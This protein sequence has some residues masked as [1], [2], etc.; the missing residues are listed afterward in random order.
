MPDLIGRTLG[1]YRITAKIGEGGMG[2]VYRAQDERL[3]RD[4]AI[5]LLPEEVARTWDRLDRFERGAKAVARLDH[6][7]ILAIHD[8]GSDED[9]TYSITELLQGETL[10]GASIFE[11]NR[12]AVFR[13]PVGGAKLLQRADEEPRGSARA[14]AEKVSEISMAELAPDFSQPRQRRQPIGRLSVVS[15]LKE[16]LVFGGGGRGFESTGGGILQD[17]GAVVF[18]KRRSALHREMHDGP[19]V[20]ALGNDVAL[21]RRGV[22][23]DG[24]CHPIHAF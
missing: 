5:K 9:V 4:V 19:P 1:H 3:D 17:Q 2:E 22:Q 11:P 20:E 12:G 16:P 21:G 10:R 13:R 7:N 14:S 6:P 18:P 8:F 23:T 24:R 15:A